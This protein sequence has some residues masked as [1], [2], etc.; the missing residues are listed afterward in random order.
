MVVVWR[1]T[2]RNDNQRARLS[3][4]N[5]VGKQGATC[6]LAHRYSS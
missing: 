4:S 6:E 5:N 1:G 3:L 2:V